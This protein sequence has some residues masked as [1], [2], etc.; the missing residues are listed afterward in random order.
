MA[1]LKK[2]K[3]C[4][5]LNH[6]R[7]ECLFNP[8]RY[9]KNPFL[10]HT[11]HCCFSFTTSSVIPTLGISS[12][13]SRGKGGGP[14]NSIPFKNCI[15]MVP[16]ASQPQALSPKLS[17]ET[18]CEPPIA[19]TSTSNMDDKSDRTLSRLSKLPAVSTPPLPASMDVCKLR[20]LPEPNNAAISFPNISMSNDIGCSKCPSPASL[21]ETLGVRDGNSSIKPP[22]H[23]GHNI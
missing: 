3:S 7:K 13:L 8:N 18:V 17:R 21:A 16:N 2:K 19:A 22:P 11:E 15:T 10:Q 5:A 4:V 14:D 1:E 20:P 23:K 6:F 9:R 12:I